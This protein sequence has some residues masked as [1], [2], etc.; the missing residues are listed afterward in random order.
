[1][2]AT[3]ATYA[4]RFL[5][6]H[7]H[8]GTGL[9]RPQRDRGRILVTG[10]GRSILVHS[11]PSRITERAF[12]H[13]LERQSQDPLGTEVP[14]SHDSLRINQHNTFVQRVDD[15][16]ISRLAFSQLSLCLF[17]CGDV[18]AERTET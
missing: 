15:R 11:V 7:D 2:H 6:T 14:R 13:F 17:L 16:A 18:A 10:E 4:I 5:D 3:P 12:H 8:S 1:M 9:A